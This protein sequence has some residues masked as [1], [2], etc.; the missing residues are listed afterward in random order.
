[1]N[2]HQETM[3]ALPEIQVDFLLMDKAVFRTRGHILAEGALNPSLNLMLDSHML[4][5]ARLAGQSFLTLRTFESMAGFSP[6][7]QKALLF[8]LMLRGHHWQYFCNLH[9]WR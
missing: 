3:E 8:M 1:M 6:F 2:L 4:S 5:Q 9:V 7:P